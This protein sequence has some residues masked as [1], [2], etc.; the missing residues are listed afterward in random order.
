MTDPGASTIRPAVHFVGF[1]GDEYHSAV[2]IFGEP[3]FI[4]IGWDV[5][6]KEAIAPG[7]TAVFARGTF[8]DPPSQYS[9]PD[10]RE[11]GVGNKG[12]DHDAVE[13]SDRSDRHALS[14]TFRDRAVSWIRR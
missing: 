2:R 11:D 8:D 4:H 12:F 7:D 1:R 5:W 14:S 10:P 9:F 3:D 13:R 6:A